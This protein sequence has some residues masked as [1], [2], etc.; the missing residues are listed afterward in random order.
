MEVSSHGLKQYR[1]KDIPFY[2]GIFTNLTQDHLD[3]HKNMK[4]Y[5]L[6]KW[7]FFS[8]HKVKKI[9]IN[10]NDEYGKNG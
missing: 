7:S 1:V 10:A 5:E 9:I 3:Y 2:I 4:Q 6:A 8:Q